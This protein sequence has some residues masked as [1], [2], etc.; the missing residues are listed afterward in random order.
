MV[1]FSKVIESDEFE[2]WIDVMKEELKSMEENKVWDIVDFPIGAKWVECKWVFMTKRDSKGN[3]EWYKAK[4][5]AKGFSQKD[6]IDYK[7][8][9]S[10][11]LKKDSLR[12]IMALV[13]HLNLK[14]H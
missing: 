10:P 1:L 14:L 12:I 3:D 5:V 7:K 8:T 4:L 6:G 9:F 11:I 13:A 2:K